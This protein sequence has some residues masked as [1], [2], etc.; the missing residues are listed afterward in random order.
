M[1]L[2]ALYITFTFF[3]FWKNYTDSRTNRFIFLLLL[4]SVINEFLTLHL[5]RIEFPYALNTTVFIVIHNLIWLYILYLNTNLKRLISFCLLAYLIFSLCNLLF[6]EG[7]HAFN[8]NSFILGAF[9]YMALF[10]YESLLQLKKENLAFF[11]SAKYILLAAPVLFFLGFSFV[12]GFKSHSLGD[13]VLFNNVSLYDFISHFV[14]VIYYTLLNIYVY[15]EK[16]L[17]NAA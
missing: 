4:L 6:L 1:D 12:F 10:I 14:N 16:K 9:M 11:M 17:K 2:I 7:L 3:F 15:R 8:Y 5:V 13:I